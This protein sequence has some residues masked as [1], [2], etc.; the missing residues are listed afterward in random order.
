MES[1]ETFFD[2]LLLIELDQISYSNSFKWF[3]RKFH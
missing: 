3:D 1:T 2:P